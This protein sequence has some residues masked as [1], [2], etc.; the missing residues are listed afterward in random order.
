M[1]SNKHIIVLHGKIKEGAGKDEED[2]LVQAAVV[3]ES[4]LRLGFTTETVEVDLNLDSLRTKLSSSKPLA[5]FY[6]VEA[7]EGMGR[8]I[9]I[10]ALVL[11]EL[12]IPYTGNSS[13]AITLT[14]SKTMAK[15]ILNGKGLPTPR[16]CSAQDAL[17]NPSSAPM[18]CIIKHS[19]EHASIG[20]SQDS[21]VFTQEKL[22][23]KLESLSPADRELFFLEEF[24]DGRE[25]NI[26]V[27]ETQNSPIVLPHA[28]ILF[29]GY[30]NE[31]IKIVD[32]SAKW[33]EGSYAFSNTPRS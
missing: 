27:L 10:P 2:T 19:I 15:L 28:E 5:V 24:I 23:A 17:K 31:R 4:L 12:G 21:V 22:I 6:L 25:F 3:S 18:P 32:Y 26:S 13:D 30:G 7:I 9:T 11:D 14:S 16:S 33:D 29:N 1:H 8:Y 20:L